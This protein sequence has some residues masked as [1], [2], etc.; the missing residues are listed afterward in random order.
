MILVDTSVWINHFREG[1]RRLHDLLLEGEVACHPFVIG[2]LACG[3][4]KNRTEILELLQ[5]LPQTRNVS[6]EEV[7]ALIDG[8]D[9]QGK[10]IGLIDIHLLASALV[11]QTRFWTED[12]RLKEI[13]LKLKL[14]SQ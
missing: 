2:E 9:L 14:A 4:L 13:A 10:G 12:K 1:N 3:N 5:S 8:R 7:L 6:L 11:S